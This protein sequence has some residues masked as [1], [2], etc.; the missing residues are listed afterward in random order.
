MQNVAVVTVH[1]FVLCKKTSTF[2]DTSIQL[3]DL[4][5]VHLQ[6]LYFSFCQIGLRLLYRHLYGHAYKF[7]SMT[8]T[9]LTS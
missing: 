9:L 6:D 3:Y 2:N 8:T 1:V 7:R 5:L 4:I